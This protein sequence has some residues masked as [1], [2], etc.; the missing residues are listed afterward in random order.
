VNLIFQLRQEIYQVKM[1]ELSFH[2]LHYVRCPTCNKVLADTG[3][4]RQYQQAVG[5]IEEREMLERRLEEVETRLQVLREE[6]A[7]SRLITEVET[8]AQDLREELQVGRREEINDEIREL[9]RQIRRASGREAEEL[10]RQ[11]RQLE[12][13]R[14]ELFPTKEAVLNQLGF[15]R[16]CCRIRFMNPGQLPLGTTSD[17]EMTAQIEREL[18]SDSFANTLPGLID[19]IADLGGRSGSSLTMSTPQESQVSIH[20]PGGELASEEPLSMLSQEEMET[21]RVYFA[22]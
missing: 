9:R 19:T 1:E 14:R 11:E 12:V 22:R 17:P 13:T 2:D 18:S 20:R 4:I 10:R 16:P 21:I 8:Q 6:G 7:Q 15:T 5:R 3:K